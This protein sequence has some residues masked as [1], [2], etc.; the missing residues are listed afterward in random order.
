M[1]R[2]GGDYERVDETD[3]ENQDHRDL[4]KDGYS[5]SQVFTRRLRRMISMTNSQSTEKSKTSISTW[6]EGRDF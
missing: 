2:D 1:S 6:T 5:S 3:G 4:L